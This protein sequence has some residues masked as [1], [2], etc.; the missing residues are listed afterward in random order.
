MD[1]VYPVDVSIDEAS[2]LR[3]V[4]PHLPGYATPPEITPPAPWG[5]C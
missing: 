2:F 3:V 5:R 1:Y 4:F